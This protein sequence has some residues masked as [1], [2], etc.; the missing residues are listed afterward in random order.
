MTRDKAKIT[1]LPEGAPPWQGLTEKIRAAR[2]GEEEPPAEENRGLECRRCG[3]RHFHVLETRRG[4]DAII[5]RRECRNCGWRTTTR[6][7][8]I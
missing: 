4:F 2:S 5:R 1:P 8:S 6:E 7:S 3:C